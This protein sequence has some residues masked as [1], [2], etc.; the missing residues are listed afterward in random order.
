MSDK[1][2]KQTKP[3]HSVEEKWGKIDDNFGYENEDERHT[4]R[5]LEDWE[6]VAHMGKSEQGIPYWFVAVFMVLLLVA[7]GL[8]FPFW[9]NREGYEREWFDWGIPAGAAWVIFM[10]GLIYYMVDYRHVLKKKKE[11]AEAAAKEQEAENQDK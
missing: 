1:E 2:V 4:K 7:I 6:M 8:T 5:G 11:E 3:T 10:S 9:G